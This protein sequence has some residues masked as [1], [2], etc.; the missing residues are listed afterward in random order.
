MTVDGR[1]GAKIRATVDGLFQSTVYHNTKEV[2][3]G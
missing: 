1:Q 3:N 2:F